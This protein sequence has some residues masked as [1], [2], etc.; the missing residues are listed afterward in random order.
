MRRWTDRNPLDAEPPL[1]PIP[2]H[3]AVVTWLRD[4]V[5]KPKPSCI[6]RWLGAST[7]FE[8]EVCAPQ[9]VEQTFFV[10][11]S[12]FTVL[13]EY[14]LLPFTALPT[15]SWGYFASTGE[16]IILIRPSDDSLPSLLRCEARDL[17]E[18]DPRWM[19]QFLCDIQFSPNCLNHVVV[20]NADAI[21]TFAQNVPDGGYVLDEGEFERTRHSIPAPHI[22]KT[23]AGGWRLTFAS[24]YGWMHDVQE[25]G[26]EQIEI[27]SDYRISGRGR[28]KLSRRMFL[29][30]PYIRY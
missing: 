30:V 8:Y 28:T 10:R 4:H 29:E 11:H 19:G 5:K 12:I 27:S 23:Q 13:A 2:D 14:G 26:V 22:C 25:L 7:S 16:S 18:G 1:P 20:A 17:C 3:P 24:L 6:A 15:G 21:S 9:H